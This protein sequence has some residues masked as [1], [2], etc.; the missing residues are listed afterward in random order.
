MEAL[1]VLA[2]KKFQNIDM[3]VNNAGHSSSG[4]WERTVAVNCQGIVLGTLLGFKYLGVDG[5]G[6]GGTIINI[7]S[8]TGLA[9]CHANPVFSASKHFTIGFS[10]SVGTE[11]F[12][13]K[14]NVKVLT[15]CPG[16]TQT[17]HHDRN[18]EGLP[19]FPD[20]GKELKRKL[21]CFPQQSPE[22]VGMAFM[23]VL[24][25]GENGSVW[26]AENKEV[27]K[28]V[29]PDRRTFVPRKKAGHE[30]EPSQKAEPPKKEP[31]K[32][33]PCKKT[34]P[35]KQDP[36]KKAEPPKKDPSKKESPKQDP[37]K[38]G[39]SKKAESPT[40]E[41]P[42][43]DPCKK[44]EPPKQDP[45]KKAEP[46]KKDPGKKE[47][48]K[49]DP[50]KQDPC[51]KAEPP[52]KDPCKKESQK[53][54]PPKQDPCKKAEPSKQEPLKTDP[55]NKAEPLIKEPTKKDPSQKGESKKDPS[56]KK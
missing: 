39:P 36:C 18:I 40:Q 26:V 3:V 31:P 50:P 22:D 30:K 20:L 52:K 27:Y 48:Q 12:F 1:F 15:L 34:E 6:K 29:L 49:Q 19:E 44:T 13:K 24:E 37:P 2:K 14:T 51:K 23:Q 28:C 47:S 8:V 17:G 10:R 33:D 32:E 45:C 25:D 55:C 56:P 5:G 4:D 41:P 38:Q 42:K 9:P 7:S 35:P 53:Q 11:Y 21:G 43:E 54:D 46:P 16:A